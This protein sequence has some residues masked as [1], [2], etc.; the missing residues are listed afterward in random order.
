MPSKSFLSSE[1]VPRNHSFGTTTD[2]SLID[3]VRMDKKDQA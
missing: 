3:R 1:A 2:I